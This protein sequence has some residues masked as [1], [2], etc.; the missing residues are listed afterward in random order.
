MCFTSRRKEETSTWSALSPQP[1]QTHIPPSNGVYDS[2]CTNQ[3][4]GESEWVFRNELVSSVYEELSGYSLSLRELPWVWQ[5]GIH[6]GA[7]NT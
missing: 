2:A 3:L 6:E 4:F 1:R 7:A 5:Y